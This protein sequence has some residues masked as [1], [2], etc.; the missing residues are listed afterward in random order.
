MAFY[1][2][3]PDIR[4]IEENGI[5]REDSKIII[6]MIQEYIKNIR[7]EIPALISEECVLLDIW[8]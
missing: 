1:V 3:M 5:S 2:L 6:T 8:H 7:F 4:S